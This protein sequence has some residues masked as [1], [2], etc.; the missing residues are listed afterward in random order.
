MI[1]ETKAPAV[2]TASAVSVARWVRPELTRLGALDAVNNI[3][4]GINQATGA[5]RS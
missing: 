2:S 4:R 3:G 1:S 5:R